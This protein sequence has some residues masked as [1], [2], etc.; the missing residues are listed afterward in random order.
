VDYRYCDKCARDP[1]TN[2]GHSIGFDGRLQHQPWYIR[3]WR[4][5]YYVAVIW[6]TPLLVF[7]GVDPHEA[8]GVCW[9]HAQAQMRYCYSA[10]EVFGTEDDS[11]RH[12]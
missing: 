5:R 10:D 9:G 11:L 1:C 2:L 3:L 6:N 7:L 8:W 12:S 4:Y